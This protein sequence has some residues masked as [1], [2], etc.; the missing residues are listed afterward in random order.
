MLARRV[1]RAYGEWHDHWAAGLRYAACWRT[2]VWITPAAH[3]PARL[4]AVALY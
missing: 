1:N 4:W 3:G 2:S